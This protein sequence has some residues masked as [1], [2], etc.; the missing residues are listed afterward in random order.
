MRSGT[1]KV[2]RNASPPFLSVVAPQALEAGEEVEKTAPAPPLTPT[3][4]YILGTR[5]GDG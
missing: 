1:R 5:S 2:R 3:I 4:Y